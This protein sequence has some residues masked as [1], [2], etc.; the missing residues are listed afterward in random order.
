MIS[1]EP[2][3]DRQKIKEIERKLAMLDTEIGRKEYLL[4]EIG[5]YLAR[6]ISDMIVMRVGDLRGRDLFVVREKKTGKRIELPIPDELQK[7]L[8]QRL[9]GMADGEYIFQSR[10]KDN[11]G[12]A[13]HISRKTA[14][15]YVKAIGKLGEI[16]YPFAC[17][18]LRK[19]FGYHYYMRTKDIAMLMDLFNHTKESTTLIYIGIAIDEKRKAL[20]KWKY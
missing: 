13:S 12:R 19:T 15:N 10:Q 6:R 7:V 3:R 2:I 11:K 20:T 16:E 9:K 14:Y 5:I 18:S 4:F 17:H 8:R 1:V